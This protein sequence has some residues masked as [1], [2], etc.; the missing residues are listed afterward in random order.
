MLR[1]IASHRMFCMFAVQSSDEGISYLSALPENVSRL[2]LEFAPI[3]CA[4]FFKVVLQLLITVY[5]KNILETNL[6]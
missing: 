4:R 2:V 3:M 6:Y 1:E 5:L